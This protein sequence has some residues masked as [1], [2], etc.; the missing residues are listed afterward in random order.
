M[1]ELVLLVT[2]PPYWSCWCGCPSPTLPLPRPFLGYFS[3]FS[4]CLPHSFLS[5]QSFE[6]NSQVFRIGA[7]ETLDFWGEN[8]YKERK[9]TKKRDNQGAAATPKM[10]PRCH[11]QSG[12]S[13]LKMAAPS[14]RWRRRPQWASMERRDGRDLPKMAP[15]PFPR[16]RRAAVKMA[17]GPRPLPPRF[18]V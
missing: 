11:P 7:G 8:Y 15:P 13:L 16:W 18:R 10:A 14:S 9:K 17:P 5:Q 12:G 6:V 4:T 1:G 3:P 2:P